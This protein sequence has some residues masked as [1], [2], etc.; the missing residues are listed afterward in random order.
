MI[1]PEHESPQSASPANA[2]PESVGTPT[3]VADDPSPRLPPRYRGA[4]GA[5]F[6][7]ALLLAVGLVAALFAGFAVGAL[8]GSNEL[9]GVV[10]LRVLLFCGSIAISAGIARF[11]AG[12]ETE[13]LFAVK[14]VR[15]DYGGIVGLFSGLL[16]AGTQATFPA[17]FGSTANSTAPAIAIGDRPEITG[18]LLSG[19]KWNLADHAGKVVLVDFWATWCHP[20]VEELPFVKKVYDRYHDQ[21]LEVVAVSLDGSQ[22]ALER[23]LEQHPEPWPQIFFDPTEGNPLTERYHVESIPLL[24]VIGRDGQVVAADVRG[25]QIDRAVVAALAGESFSPNPMGGGILFRMLVGVS[26][27]VLVAP[28]YLL[29]PAI[30][31]CSAIGAALE[32]W[33]RGPGVMNHLNRPTD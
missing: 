1:S 29:T 19:G 5:A 20:C 13:R 22:S 8:T 25:S 3:S 27:A 24:V 23:F 28:W 15:G 11:I 33:L 30:V 9:R 6:Y 31:V 18:P 21:G 16:I 32:A 14:P 17:T 4:S 12:G 7:A 26:A 2:S 10:F